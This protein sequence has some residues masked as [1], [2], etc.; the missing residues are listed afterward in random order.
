LATPLKKAA[1]L[2][3]EIVALAIMPDHVHL[4]FS[5][6]PGVAPNQ[7]A[8]RLKGYT[9]HLL[10]RELPNLIRLPSLWTRSYFVS[11]AGRVSSKTIEQYTAAQK[12]R[13]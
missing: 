12:T 7:L 11:A 9:S 6:D 2:E 10:R 4:F 8:H 5:V 13:G 1:K 3:W